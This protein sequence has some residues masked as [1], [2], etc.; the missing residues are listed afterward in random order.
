MREYLLKEMSGLL[1]KAEL[2]LAKQEDR[3]KEAEKVM[4]QKDPA[5]SLPLAPPSASEQP[6]PSPTTAMFRPYPDLKPSLLEKESSYQ[7]VVHFTQVWESYIVAG[8]GSR[9]NIPQEMVHIQL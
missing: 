3:I 8:Y 6:S 4:S 1:N 5:P 9:K 7:E 2:A